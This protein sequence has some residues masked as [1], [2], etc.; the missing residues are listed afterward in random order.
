MDLK[1]DTYTTRGGRKR[2]ETK[3]AR[4]AEIARAKPQDKFTSLAH[5]INAEMIKTCHKQMDKNKAVGIDGISKEEYEANLE[6]NIEDLIARMKRQ[7]YKPQSVKRVYIPKPGTDKKRPL[8]LPAYEDKLVQMAVAKI[9]NAIYE[10]DFLECSFGFRPQRSCHDALKV[11]NKIVNKPEIN[12]IVDADIRGF[13]DHV[14]QDWMMKFIKH[15][16]ADPN[17]QRLI[18]RFMK[19]GVIEV[20]ISLDTP[21]G[22]QQGGPMSPI[23]AN[24]YLHYV[25][26]LWFEKRIRRQCKGTSYMV[27]YADD[28]VFCFQYESEA[29]EF[30]QQLIVRLKEFNLE[31]AG[32]KTKIINL[33]KN[34]DDDN[35][36]DTGSFDFLG[37]THYAD[38]I[39]N[40]QTLIK[41]KTSKKKY[42]ASLL[43]VK[44]WLKKN[45]HWPTKELMRMLKIKLQGYCRYYGV[46]NNKN[47]VSNFI[48]ETKRSL[49]K[50]LNRRSQR[51]SFDWSKF[52]LFINKYPLPRACTYVNIFEMGAGKSYVM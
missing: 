35:D 48:D 43:K 34:R 28:S 23:L 19:A 52:K 51:K 13:F 41:Q 50:W 29:K 44:E 3:L 15:R 18:S 40:G 11:L 12:Y 5:L 10:Q 47:S 45:R 30:Y 49:F 16:I 6:E 7:A 38:K 26:D 27:R 31:I 42:K 9:L 46:T 22:V 17:I 36:S 24:I 2:M 20:G 14:D 4:I 8:G 32:E 1:R 33:G 25:M 21:E 37:F 39:D